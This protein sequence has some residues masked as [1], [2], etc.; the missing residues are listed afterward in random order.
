MYRAF[1]E[2]AETLHQQRLKQHEPLELVKTLLLTEWGMRTAGLL[3]VVA[4]LSCLAGWSWLID[5]KARAKSRVRLAYV[6]SFLPSAIATR[7]V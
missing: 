2:E 5:H 6:A 3:C 1:H 4:L 7:R